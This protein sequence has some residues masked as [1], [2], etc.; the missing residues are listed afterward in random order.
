MKFFSMSSRSTSVSTT[1][2][3]NR[4]SRILKLPWVPREGSPHHLGRVLLIHQQ[5]PDHRKRSQV[6]VLAGPLLLRD[7]LD[8][9]QELCHRPFALLRH[10]DREAYEVALAQGV[11]RRETACTTT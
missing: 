9:R 5:G 3:P 11:R 1:S 8:R 4:A 10:H 6:A 7:F 2:V